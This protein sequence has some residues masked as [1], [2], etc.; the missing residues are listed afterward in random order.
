MGK[1]I[2]QLTSYV[3]ISPPSILLWWFVHPVPSSLISLFPL[4][5]LFPLSS[6]QTGSTST[7]MR[8]AAGFPTCSGRKWR[9]RIREAR[10]SAS[11]SGTTT[12][13]TFWYNHSTHF[14]VQ[15]QH[16]QRSGKLHASNRCFTHGHHR[17]KQF[18]LVTK[19]F[20]KM[21]IING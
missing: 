18:L 17:W 6:P 20:K 1:N 9:C 4:S 8:R 2:I 13:L 14:L 10:P 7:R 11:L 21:L 15:P 19:V 5:P 12:A 3:A 16:H